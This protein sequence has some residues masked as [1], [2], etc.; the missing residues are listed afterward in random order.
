[1]AGALDKAIEDIRQIQTKARDKN[2]TTRPRWP[3]IVLRSPKGWTGPQMV[4]GLKIEG[5]FRSHQ[6]PILVDAEHP[7]HLE[8]L[9]SWM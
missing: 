8:L 5:T 7:H 3:M 1:M 9:E 2:D 6:V 4:D